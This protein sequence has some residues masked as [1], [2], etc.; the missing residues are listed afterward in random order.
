M[1]VRHK[2]RHRF[3]AARGRD[4]ALH[5]HHGGG[6]VVDTRSVAGRDG[7]VLLQEG[8]FEFGHIGHHAIGPEVFVGVERH[9]ALA[10]FLHDRKDLLL[11]IACL[12]GA[13]GAVVTLHRQ[14][15]LVL[16]RDVH[17]GRDVFGGHTHVDIVK[18]VV[19]CA[20][21]HVDHLAVTHA[22]APAA[23]QAGIGCAAHVLRAAANGNVGV[24]QSNGLRRRYDGLQP[25]T[26]QPVDIEGGRALTTSA[27]QGR[28]AREVHV[29]RFG[30]DDMAKHHM[31]DLLSLDLGAGQRL[32]HHLG[33]QITGGNVFQ[34]TT[35]GANCGANSADDDDFSDH[36]YSSRKNGSGR[37]CAAYGDRDHKS[38]LISIKLCRD[39]AQAA[40]AA[41]VTGVR[42][43]PR[44]GIGLSVPQSRA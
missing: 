11:E 14:R 15:I 27:L 16:A 13:F 40:S 12:G 5:Q 18:R 10:G 33:G 3:E 28:H 21:H 32:L 2:A 22:A 38:D 37:Q 8:G 7:T 30:I 4:A 29:A 26:T 23:G 34:A 43:A 17:L 41:P 1:R 9:V 20:D 24:A 35:K 25:G 36:E 19:Q 42:P 44:W 6:R 31:A 39:R